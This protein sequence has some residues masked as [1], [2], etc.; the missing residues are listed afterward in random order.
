[1]IEHKLVEEQR[2][3]ANFLNVTRLIGG[4]ILVITFII[5]LSGL[6]PCFMPIEDLPKYWSMNVKDYIHTLNA[7]TGWSWVIMIGKGDYLNF[8]G[9]A[10]MASLTILCYLRILPILMKKKD[11]PYVIVVILEVAILILAASGILKVEG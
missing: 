10:T 1:V 11:I 2:A 4:V 5:Y 3:Y 8:V 7:P 9:I 6:L